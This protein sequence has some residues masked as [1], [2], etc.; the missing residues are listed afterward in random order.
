MSSAPNTTTTTA[1]T[2]S[3]NS[4]ESSPSVKQ[5]QTPSFQPKPVQAPPLLSQRTTTFSPLPEPEPQQDREKERDDNS[6]R[7]S[8]RHQMSTIQNPMQS[9]PESDA[10]KSIQSNSKKNTDS[11]PTAVWHAGPGKIVKVSRRDN[12]Y[13]WDN[14]PESSAISDSSYSDFSYASS[15]Q[16]TK[17]RRIRGANI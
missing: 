15:V 7:S 2:L 14:D 9:E 3:I 11:A 16:Q 4:S 10:S 12:G 5:S 8:S 13:N 6:I 1:T 17:G